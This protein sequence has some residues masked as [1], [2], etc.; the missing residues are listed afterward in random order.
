M[1]KKGDQLTFGEIS[2]LKWWIQN[3]ADLNSELMGYDI[4]KE[5]KYILIRDYNLNPVKRSFIE[6]IKINPLP[7]KKLNSLKS[8]GWEITPLAQNNHLL[9]VS[10]AEGH[11]IDNEQIAE[12]SEIKD[13]ITWLNLGNQG[14]RNDD[15]TFISNFS[16][17]TRLRIENNY[18]S[19]EGVKHLVNLHNLVSLNIYNN[20]ITDNSLEHIEQ[21]QNLKKLFL[22]KTNITSTG[23]DR[24]NQT[25]SD[26]VINAG[27]P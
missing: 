27:Y 21:L 9:E 4:T 6:T 10:V 18:V 24:I 7:L 22:W 16:N 1:P 3:G 20:P 5:I 17:L 15:L 2:L 14:I 12:L 23:I 13:H 26:I 11:A 19:D 8:S 25:R